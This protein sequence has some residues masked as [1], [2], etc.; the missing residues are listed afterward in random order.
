MWN[1]SNEIERQTPAADYFKAVTRHFQDKTIRYIQFGA[2]HIQTCDWT[3]ER[4]TPIK[5]IK[6]R[7][8]LALSGII[9]KLLLTFYTLETQF[10]YKFID[11]RKN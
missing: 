7:V 11:V 5:T 9:I 1:Y 2:K 10:Y 6:I 4:M 8:V 3:K